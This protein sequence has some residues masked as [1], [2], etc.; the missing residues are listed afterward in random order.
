MRT[1]SFGFNT[2]S[3]GGTD[4]SQVYLLKE[5][6]QSSDFNITIPDESRVL[7]LDIKLESGTP[8]VAIEWDDTHS[9]ILPATPI[10]DTISLDITRV[11]ESSADI[12]ITITGIGE[13]SIFVSYITN[14]D[15]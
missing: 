9:E 11:I 12:A 1:S 7:W 8:T 6:N 3:L 10:T 15:I 13:I 2:P 4:E 14:Y 5:R